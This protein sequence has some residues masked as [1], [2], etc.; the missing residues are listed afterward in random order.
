MV[1]C[2]STAL[3]LW[4]T[5]GSL[6]FTLLIFTLAAERGSCQI[7]WKANEDVKFKFGLQGQ[8]WADSTQN[9]ETGGYGQNLFCAGSG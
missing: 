5:A 1:K 8:M 6:L 3:G 7:V 4:K 9:A 2:I